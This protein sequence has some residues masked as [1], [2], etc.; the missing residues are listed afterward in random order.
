MVAGAVAPPRLDLANEDLVRAHLHAVWLAETGQY[1]GNSLKDVLDLERKGLPLREEVLHGLSDPAA[2]RRAAEHCGRIV[3]A[4][5]KDLEGAP[6]YGPG[7]LTGVMDG[8]LRSFD[9]ACNR[10]RRLYDAACQQRDQQ[11]AIVVDLGASPKAR[12]TATRLRGEAETQIRLLVDETDSLSSDFYSYRYFASEGFLPG[13]N[14]PRLPLA[15]FLPGRRGA[16]G[17]KKAE[18]RDEFVSRPRFLA[19]SEFGPRSIIYHEGSRYRVTRVILP[20]LEGGQRTIPAK[21]CQVCGYGYFGAQAEEEVC[22]ECGNILSASGAQY[23][24][25]LLKLD[26]VST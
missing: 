12:E 3:Q 23:L 14:F 13:Y 9:E 8:A 18:E 17:G 26:N 20:V 24:G 4:M 5:E 2:K 1:L 22:R 7:W 21:L 10:Y 15:A 6:W 25:N 19:L 11:H 16:G